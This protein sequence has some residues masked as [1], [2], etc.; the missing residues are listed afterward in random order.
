MDFFL[1]AFL[2]IA[3]ILLLYGGHRLEERRN[4]FIS[5]Y[6]AA[7]PRVLFH[8]T[9]NYNLA[10][11]ETTVNQFASL[12]EYPTPA[13]KDVVAPNLQTL[14]SSAWLDCSGGPVL[15]TIPFVPANRYFLVTLLDENTNV[16][17]SLGS[18]DNR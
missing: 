14:Y 2:L 1:L 5:H 4:K 6:I 10:K 16:F 9:K 13:F 11:I 12:R 17:A 7:Y 3:F 18:P 8:V 15:L